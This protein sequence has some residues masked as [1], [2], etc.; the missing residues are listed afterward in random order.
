MFKFTLALLAATLAAAPALAQIPS[1]D[2]LAQPANP[3]TS[4]VGAPIERTSEPRLRS[5]SEANR[6]DSNG[7]SA[8]MSDTHIVGTMNGDQK[9]DK[10]YVLFWPDWESDLET[11]TNFNK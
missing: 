7:S 3:T 5:V 11:P 10:D 6:L 2:A 9:N 8:R 1:K 4:N